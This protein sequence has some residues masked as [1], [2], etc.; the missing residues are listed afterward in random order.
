[1]TK[2]VLGLCLLL[3]ACGGGSDSLEGTWTGTTGSLTVTFSVNTVLEN[4]GSKVL[5]GTA[6][7]NTPR[8]F[9]NGSLGGQLTNTSLQFLASGSGTESQ[10]SS[11]VL[12]GEVSGDTITGLITLTATPADCALN[13]AAIV[14]VR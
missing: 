7:T 12:S 1:M 8:C 11:I 9:A 2:M 14:L 6:T 4:A 3:T 10:I 13:S 5:Q